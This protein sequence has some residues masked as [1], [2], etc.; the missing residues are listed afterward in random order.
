[1]TTFDS[2]AEPATIEPPPVRRSRK[3]SKPDPVFELLNSHAHREF[4]EIDKRMLLVPVEDYQRN[5]ADGRIS[6]EIAMHYD[7]VAFSCLLVIKRTNG[8]LMVADGGTRLSGALKRSDITTVPCL[9]FSGLTEK[10]EADVFLRINNN[11]RRLQVEQLHHA[12]LF[13]DHDLAIRSQRLIDRLRNHGIGFDSLSGMRYCVRSNMSAIDTVVM[14]LTQT[15]TDRHVT[16]RV[17]KGLF[18]L[19]VTMRRQDKTLA[20]RSTMNRIANTFG[21]FDAVVNAVIKPRTAGH[22]ADMAKALAKTLRITG[23]F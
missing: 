4:M 15:I 5:E 3:K 1:M 20:K 12:E 16:A 14:I 19:E 7:L 10:E 22:G 23:V 13:S 21:T 6:T 18:T 11:R 8:D 9:V 2:V 17:M